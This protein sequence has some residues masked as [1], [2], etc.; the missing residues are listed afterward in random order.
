M[1]VHR[2]LGPWYL[3]AVYQ[4]ALGIELGLR[5]IAFVAQ[6][7]LTVAYKGRTLE[8]YYVPDFLAGEVVVEIKAQ[9]VLSAVDVAQALNSMECAQSHVGLLINFGEGSLNWRR[10]VL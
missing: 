9:R 6:P 5:G 2:I 10:L 1:E 8:S 4:E 3:E 7:K